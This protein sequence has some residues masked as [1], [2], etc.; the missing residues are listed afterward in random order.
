MDS[1]IIRKMKLGDIEDVLD[2]EKEAFFTPW[3]KNAFITELT[4]NMLAK[5]YVAQVEDRVVAY[6]GM[7]LIMDEAHITNIA[8]SFKYR[9]KGIGTKIVEALIEE[10][11]NKNISGMT[12]EVR[13]SNLVAQ[14]LYKKLGFV[15]SGIR[16]SYYED[17]GEDAII[18]WSEIV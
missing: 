3:S 11:K 13:K 15:Y 1:I 17:N 10:G 16:P 8:V 6:G 18:M 14:N 4:K 7:W 9:G 5:Y 12:L 2:L